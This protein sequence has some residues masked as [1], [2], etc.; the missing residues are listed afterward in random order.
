MI[1]PFT[2]FKRFIR[3]SNDGSVLSDFL[4]RASPQGEPGWIEV[5]ATQHHLLG[6]GLHRIRYDEP[7]GISEKQR[8]RLVVGAAIF[9]ADGETEIAIGV[10]GVPDAAASIRVLINGVSRDLVQHEDIYLTSTTPGDFIVRLS[11]PYHYAQ[12]TELI[13]QAVDPETFDYPV[14]TPPQEEPE[15]E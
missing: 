12:P 8:V 11:D 5:P 6:L 2:G 4:G 13:I 10:R 9:P 1:Q 3:V 14:I 15:N 7:A